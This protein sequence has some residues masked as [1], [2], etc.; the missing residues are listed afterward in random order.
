[1]TGRGLDK[2]K[3]KKIIESDDA[4]Q[5]QNKTDTIDKRR[6]KM[7]SK[8]DNSWK[9]AKVM[10]WVKTSDGD[11]WMCPKS[12]V[13]DRKTVSAAELADCINES[14]NPQNTYGTGRIKT[15]A[16]VTIRRGRPAERG[17]FGAPFSMYAGAP[18]M[19]R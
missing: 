12:S 4:K 15:A 8:K 3:D 18:R 16:C 10:V 9:A 7:M 5:I 13:K 19:N 14:D 2:D 11:T 6:K 17:C 1:V